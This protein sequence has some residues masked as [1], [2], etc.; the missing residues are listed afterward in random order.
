MPSERVDAAEVGV[1]NTPE[2]RPE[3][4]L[5][6]GGTSWTCKLS[7]WFDIEG[8]GRTNTNVCRVIR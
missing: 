7:G 5:E 4:S 8:G 6:L 1:D 2:G 3:G